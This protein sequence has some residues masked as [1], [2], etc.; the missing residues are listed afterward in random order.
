MH[1]YFT[2]YRRF[3]FA[4]IIASYRG[5]NTACGIGFGLKAYL[6]LS[7]SCFSSNIIS[8]LCS[9]IVLGRVL[10]L[11][12]NKNGFGTV[13]PYLPFFLYLTVLKP[14][15]LFCYYL[16]F[17]EGNTP[18]DLVLRDFTKSWPILFLS[19]LVKSSL[20]SSFVISSE[21]FLPIVSAFVV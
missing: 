20:F 18:R 13:T 17:S 19:S 12:S 10:S 4:V 15:T 7:S 11:I 9:L 3:S 1:S 21:S 16:S 6:L 14:S 5:Y 8:I 2:F